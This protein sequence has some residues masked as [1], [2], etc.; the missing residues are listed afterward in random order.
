M[1]INID[2]IARSGYWY[3]A[4]KGQ[5]PNLDSQLAIDAF[6]AGVSNYNIRQNAHVP[7]LMEGMKS[8]YIQGSN[9][10]CADKELAIVGA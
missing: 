7:K 10:G 9:N 2:E 4:G 8:I 1:E 5:I 3:A 6:N